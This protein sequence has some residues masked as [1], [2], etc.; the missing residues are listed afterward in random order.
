MLKVNGSVKLDVKKTK[1]FERQT[2]DFELT[3][4]LN[5]SKTINVCTK[6]PGDRSNN[7]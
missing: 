5:F 1:L 3:V 2:R 6:L 4:E 7:S